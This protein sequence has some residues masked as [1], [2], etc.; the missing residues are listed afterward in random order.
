MKKES[1]ERSFAERFSNE[2]KSQK[3]K[4]SDIFTQLNS[5]KYNFWEINKLRRLTSEE[6]AQEKDKRYAEKEDPTNLI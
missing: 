1:I 6:D 3:T 4:K 5:S 2:E